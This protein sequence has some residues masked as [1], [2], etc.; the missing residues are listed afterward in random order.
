MVEN[1]HYQPLRH[2]IQPLVVRLSESKRRMF[3]RLDADD[4]GS[5]LDRLRE[6][7]SAVGASGPFQY[8]FL[9]QDFAQQH[10]SIQRAGWLFSL[11]SGLAIF[12]AC[13]GLFGLATY[14][15]QRRTKEIGIRKALGAT[16]AQ[17]VGLVSKEF[18]GLVGAAFVVAAPL[19]Y[20]GTTRWLNR[21][22]Y[23]TSVGVGVL[24]AA[25]GAVLLVALLTVSVHAVRAARTDP[26]T[27]LRDE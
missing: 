2:R 12:V 11:F 19:A 9:D 10:R 25:G 5:A 15:V 24:G 6:A 23:Q 20:L 4:P 3:L 7:W 14:T 13:L 27:T 8:T 16:S 26:A 21:F 1:F 17:I 22:A 18:A